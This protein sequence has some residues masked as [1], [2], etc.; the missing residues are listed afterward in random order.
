M[1]LKR[2]YQQAKKHPG[3][4]P[5]FFFI[6][7]GAGGASLYLIRL[8]RGPHVCWDRK[9]NPEPW[10]NL[11]PTYQYKL[12]AVTTDYEKLKKEGPDF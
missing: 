4:I 9:N 8:A 7:L 1:M 2:I 11:S 3:L 10:N 12:V 5:Q 6:I